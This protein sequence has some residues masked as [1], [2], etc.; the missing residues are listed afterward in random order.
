MQGKVLMLTTTDGNRQL[1]E[2]LGVSIADFDIPNSVYRLAVARY[3]DLGAWFSEY[4]DES[5]QD[6][7]IYPQGSFRLGTVVQ[8]IKEGDDYDVDLV[9][10][11]DIAKG[12]TTQAALKADCGTGITGYV[13][14]NPAGSPSRS[15]GTRCWTLDYPA[16]PFHMDV[17][18]A[19]PNTDA[20]PNAIWLTDRDLRLWQPS[21]PID[22]ADWFHARMR[23]DFIR[24]REILAKRMDVADVPW[25]QVKT[26]LQQ[27]V[28]ALKRHRDM[29]FAKAPKDKPASIIITTLAAEAYAG[30]G[31]LYEVLADVTAKMLGLVEVRNGIYWVA[32]PVQ[33]DENF[34]DRWRTRPGRDR[35]FFEWMEQVHDDVTGYG[36]N[37]G[38]GLD[39]VLEKI[40]ASFG[41]RSA[42]RAG[43]SIGTRTSR[44]RD[45]GV[46]GMASGTGLL[47]TAASRSRPV[48]QHTFH[49]SLP[50]CSER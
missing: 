42:Q 10:R 48:P 21:N 39:R 16:E 1:D 24:E 49:G 34:A 43:E 15:E 23:Q 50:E 7:L 35:R 14:S 9:C 26:P 45:A 20:A 25:W 30:G 41:E 27:T 28:Q 37:L 36:A 32:N 3:E 2:L 17:L 11:R 44:A 12:A 18:P 33:P 22:Y 19:I 46:L 31:T 5:P 29:H 6:G 40:A 38:S 13:G 47:G 4:W 8:P